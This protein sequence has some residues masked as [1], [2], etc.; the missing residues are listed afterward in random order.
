MMFLMAST[1]IFAQGAVDSTLVQT[2]GN[3]VTNIFGQSA[4]ETTVTVI[5]KVL[6]VLVSLDFVIMLVL[7]LLP[8]NSPVRTVFEVIKTWIQKLIGDRK[9]GGGTF[10]K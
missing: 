6:G 3:F 2:I 7:T 5:F 8:T 10:E 9:V 1:I 4:G